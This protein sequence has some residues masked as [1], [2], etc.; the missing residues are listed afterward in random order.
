MAQASSLA[1]VSCNNPLACSAVGDYDDASGQKHT[2]I[3]SWNGSVWSIV[4]SP[5]TSDNAPNLLNGVSCSGPSSCIAV[6]YNISTGVDLQTLIE[7]WNGSVWSI[8]PS[9]NTSPSENNSL[10][11][12]SCS[13]PSACTA[14]GIDTV[15]SINPIDQTLI[16]SW[17][18]SAWS[19]VPS[20]NVADSQDSSLAGVSCTGPSACTAVGQYDLPGKNV[21]TLIESWNGSVWSIV[22]SPDTSATQTNYLSG[23]SCN[24]PSACTAVGA[25]TIGSSTSTDQTLIE[26]WNGS[27][28]SIVPSPNTSPSEA[29]VLNGVSCFGPTTCNAVGYHT[30]G[31]GQGLLG[32]PL[33]VCETLIESWNGSAWSIVPSPNA[34]VAQANDLNG[35]SCNGPS[36]CTAVGVDGASGDQTLVESSTASATSTSTTVTSSVNPSVFGQPVSFSASI[37]PVPDGGIVQFSVDGTD[38]GGPVSVNTLTGAATSPINSSLGVGS[39]AVSARYSGDANFSSSGGSLSGG[40]RVNRAATTT[41]VASSTD[42]A[43]VGQRVTYMATVVVVPPGAG[44]PTG[45]VR[46]TDNSSPISS[47]GEATFSTGRATCTAIYPRMGS[48]VIVATYSGDTHFSGGPS[49]PLGEAATHCVFGNLGCDLAGANLENADVAG[50]VF[51]WTNLTYGDLAGADLENTTFVSTSFARANLAGAD[52][53]GAKL[54]L[55]DFGHANLANADLDG[56]R[57]FVVNVSGVVWENTT[58]PDGTNS[59]A[60]GGT[61]IG[62]L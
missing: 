52:L 22:P 28:W 9:P 59:N 45:R 7:S 19:I 12:V 14:V 26:S 50:R 32:C 15:G 49:Q 33:E 21:L 18:G 13:G 57:L 24:S 36:A 30:T 55:I 20:P 31:G 34:S 2:L 8:V 27:M 46:F 29:N 47:C 5:N 17:N 1:G 6:G 54:G 38:L 39:H 44:S 62:H 48:H 60:D 42:P 23:V 11:G 3:E 40:Q 53:M 37:S 16:E 58:C 61:C 4:P 10:N 25:N 41:T 43:R 51:G 56:A 35:V